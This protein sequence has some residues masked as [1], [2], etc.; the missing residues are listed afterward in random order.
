[1]VAG[2]AGTFFFASLPNNLIVMLDFRGKMYFSDPY[3]DMGLTCA[4]IKSIIK[5][6]YLG[7]QKQQ[8][9]Y[10][11]ELKIALSI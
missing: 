10:F 4:S 6:Q 7:F 8:N 9:H 1:M 3:C 2:L 5:M 11:L